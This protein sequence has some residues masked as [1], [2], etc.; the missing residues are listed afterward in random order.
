MWVD[1]NDVAEVGDGL[2]EF[3]LDRVDQP[4]VVIRLEII[5]IVA[6]CLGEV[7]QGVPQITLLRVDNA[8]IASS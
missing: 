4:A 3:F 1:P 5:G 7:F 6:D 2:V 8:S